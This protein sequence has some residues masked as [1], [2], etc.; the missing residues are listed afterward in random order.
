M[1]NHL[2]AQPNPQ[3]LQLEASSGYY[4]DSSTG[5]YYD[6]KTEYYYNS[7]TQAWMFYCKKYNAYIPVEGGD[8]TTKKRLQ[9]EERAERMQA[10]QIEI[11]AP[12]E[13]R[14]DM[15]ADEV[16]E[17][18]GAIFREFNVFYFCFVL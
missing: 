18:F 14:R 16:S 12:P 17:I 4:Y 7:Q 15:R 9:E 5:F 13:L 2:S 8:M 11:S 3:N 1:H 10:S 6:S